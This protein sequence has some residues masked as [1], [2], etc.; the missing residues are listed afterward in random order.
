M[1]SS[2]MTVLAYAGYDESAR[3]EFLRGVVGLPADDVTDFSAE[4]YVMAPDDDYDAGTR[5]GAIA[6]AA[7]YDAGADR[8]RPSNPD[9]TDYAYGYSDGYTG[10]WWSRAAFTEATADAS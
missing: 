1:P 8:S 9:H 3:A 2:A 5:D 6:G 4:S 10:G 7:D